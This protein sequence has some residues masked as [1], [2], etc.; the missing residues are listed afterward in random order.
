[1]FCFVYI[2]DVGIVV[3]FIFYDELFCIYFVG[4]R[5][6]GSGLGIDCIVDVNYFIGFLLCLVVDGFYESG[7]KIYW[8]FVWYENGGRFFFGNFF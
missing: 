3:V 6:V 5:D 7:V 1:M 4:N 2:V 8:G